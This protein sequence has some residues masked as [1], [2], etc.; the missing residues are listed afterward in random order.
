MQDKLWDLSIDKLRIAK[1]CILIEST[2]LIQRLIKKLSRKK[3]S[4][5]N[6]ALS[7]CSEH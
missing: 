2:N 5:E 7:C 1:K 3:A 6:N 4:T